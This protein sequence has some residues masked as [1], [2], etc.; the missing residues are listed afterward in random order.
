MKRLVLLV[1]FCGWLTRPLFADDKPPEPSAD[2][3]AIRQSVADYVEA[4][5]KHDKKKLAAFWSPEAVY[6]NRIT[7]EQVVGRDA[8]AEQFAAMFK[9]APEAKLTAK[10]ESVQ[11]VSPNVAVERGMSTVTLPKEEPDE[12]PY[13]AVYV[14]R[15]GKWLLDRVTDEAKKEEKPSHYEQL[16]SL[17]WM[18]GSWVDQDEHV[19][20]ETECSW[21]KNRNFITRSFTVSV[22]GRSGDVGH[23]GHRLG[24]SG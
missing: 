5:N 10:T 23:A 4:F 7:G 3:K 20:I 19:D 13:S 17:E 24:C 22:D 14:K 16:K 1:L 12:I 8:I 9:D 6:L 11:F 15:D 2:E 21:A 18:V